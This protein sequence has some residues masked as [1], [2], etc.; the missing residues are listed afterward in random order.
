MGRIH[1][2]QNSRRGRGLAALGFCAFVV[3]HGVV[4]V[5]SAAVVPAGLEARIERFVRDCAPQL[6]TSIEIP[7]LGDFALDDVDPETVDVR[8]SARSRQRFAGAVPITVTLVSDGREVKRGIVTVQI[9]VQRPAVVA[10]RPLRKGKILR[11]ADLQIESRDLSALPTDWIADVASVVGQRIR[12][13]VSP[14]VPLR[15]LWIEAAP[16]VVRG[17]VVPVRLVHGALL[18]ETRGRARSDGRAGDRIRVA[19]GEGLRDIVGTLGT[20]GVVNVE[21]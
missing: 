9:R 7:P 17:Q 2:R 11:P 18:I 20:D 4:T 3:I 21:F 16:L 5:A 12:R 10:T 13:G 8:L 14:G 19:R 1:E 6:P 15:S